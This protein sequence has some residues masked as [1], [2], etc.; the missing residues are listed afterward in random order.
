MLN[1]CLALACASTLVLGASM[2]A[3]EA[4]PL[5]PASIVSQGAGDVL[6]VMYGM[7][8]KNHRNAPNKYC[9]NQPSRC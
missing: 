6:P 9:R 3:A 5:K 1:V 4:M 2:S 7:H 8:R